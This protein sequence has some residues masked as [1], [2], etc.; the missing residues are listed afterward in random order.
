MFVR[1]FPRT[2]G[3]PDKIQCAKLKE[4]RGSLA[5]PRRQDKN[6][7]YVRVV[8]PT[9]W[10]RENFVRFFF[11]HRVPFT[12]LLLRFPFTDFAAVSGRLLFSS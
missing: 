7:Y 8:R 11:Y 6:R 2:L 5:R 3:N 10:T 12:G 4:R 9:T 1:R